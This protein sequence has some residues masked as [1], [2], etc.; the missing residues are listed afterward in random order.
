M[1]EKESIEEILSNE[2]EEILANPD[3]AFEVSREE[4]SVFIW[5]FKIKD[6]KDLNN[7]K[8][9]CNGKISFS[10]EYP[11]IP[12][13]VLILESTG[14]LENNSKFEKHM[15]NWDETSN[16]TTVLHLLADFMNQK[17]E[18]EE[19]IKKVEDETIS[20]LDTPRPLPSND[21]ARSIYPII[22]ISILLCFLGIVYVVLFY[23]KE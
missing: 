11:T 1:S 9:I 18:K 21:L 7:E 16:A 3:D 6:Q 20:F 14:K 13:E 19:E 22:D 2:L 10:E 8:G 15:E 5:K 17:E 12:P 4:D 23:K